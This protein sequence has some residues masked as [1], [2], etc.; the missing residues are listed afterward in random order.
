MRAFGLLDA[1]RD[2]YQADV[3][4]C[5]EQ[6]DKIQRRSR[7]ADGKTIITLKNLTSAFI[8][9]IFGYFLSFLTFLVEQIVYY[10]KNETY[11]V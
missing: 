5:L 6:A 2:T 1:W 10:M 8:V 4:Q 11:Q 9:L 3:H 7:S